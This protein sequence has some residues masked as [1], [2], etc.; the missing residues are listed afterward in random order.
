MAHMAALTCHSACVQQTLQLPHARCPTSVHC[1]CLPA[2]SVSSRNLRGS[3]RNR[4]QMCRA[5]ADV[6][7]SPATQSVLE[8]DPVYEGEYCSK[9]PAD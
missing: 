5:T 3:S 8:L 1:L 9:F 4:A 6:D 7:T 2:H